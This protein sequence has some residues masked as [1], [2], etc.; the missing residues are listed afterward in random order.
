MAVCGVRFGFFATT[1]L[2]AVRDVRRRLLALQIDV[3]RMLSAAVA[4]RDALS[5]TF[6][7]AA[8]S[9]S[10]YHRNHETD[11]A[12]AF[13]NG[14]AVAFAGPSSTHLEMA[15]KLTVH[16]EVGYCR[17]GGH[18]RDMFLLELQRLLESGVSKRLRACPNC[19]T[20]F[21]RNRRQ[22]YCTE[23]C[24]DRLY[25]KTSAAAERARLKYYEK[26]NWTLGA[27]KKK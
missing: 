5:D 17:L 25:W 10:G 4:G 1:N 20:L 22:A 15:V 8:A 3:C 2:R 19:R 14:Q 7:R 26:N 23:V 24:R 6:A 16:V 21:L 27:R 9:P 12:V 13:S 11:T 18:P